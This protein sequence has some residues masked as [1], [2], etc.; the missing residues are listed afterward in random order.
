MKW[1]NAK[2]WLLAHFFSDLLK[3]VREGLL[4]IP[5]HRGHARD[6]ADER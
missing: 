4:N 2:S 3:H 5:P 1:C 6:G